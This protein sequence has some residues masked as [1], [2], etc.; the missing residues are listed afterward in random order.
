MSGIDYSEASIEVAKAIA[1]K[2]G[3]AQIEFITRDVI[4]DPLPE[5]ETWDLVLDKGTLD[6]ISLS[7]QKRDGKAMWEV[8]VGRIARLVRRDGGVLL[9]TSCNF[10]K[11]ELLKKFVTLETGQFFLFF[12]SRVDANLDFHPSQSGLKYYSH[13]PRP[14]FQFGGATGSTITTVAF[15]KS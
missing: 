12:S 2:D 1:T 11:E 13:I 5:E 8:Y 9:I 15:S 7:D 10:T 3:L 14:T 6:G 4:D